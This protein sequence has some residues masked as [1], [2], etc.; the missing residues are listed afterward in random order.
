MERVPAD[1]SCCRRAFLFLARSRK[2]QC[3][4][5]D[6]ARGSRFLE[7]LDSATL[8]IVTESGASTFKAS[9]SRNQAARQDAAIRPASFD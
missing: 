5:D 4:T 6:T 9:D 3:G 7:M 1:G 2:E 8:R